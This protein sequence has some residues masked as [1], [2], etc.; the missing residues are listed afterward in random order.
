MKPNEQETRNIIRPD[1]K[2][3]TEFCLALNSRGECLA[4]IVIVPTILSSAAH[5]IL[6]VYIPWQH[7]T[8]SVSSV[9]K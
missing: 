9:V 1:A 7:L 5:L 2:P 3:E 4:T 6:L 8:N